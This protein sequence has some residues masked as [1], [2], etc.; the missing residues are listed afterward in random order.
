MMHASEHCAPDADPADATRGNARDYHADVA[1]FD[2]IPDDLK[3]LPQWVCWRKEPKVNGGFTKIP[4]NAYTGGNAQ[5]N[6]PAT[7][8]SYDTAVAAFTRGRGDGIGFVV[9]ANDPYC[10]IDLDHCRDPLTGHLNALAAEILARCD[11]Y[12]EVTPSGDGIRVWMKAQLSGSG[13]NDNNGFEVYDRARFF[14]MTGEH[15]GGTPPTIEPRQDIVAA[16]Y[17]K[18]FPNKTRDSTANGNGTAHTEFNEAEID[19]ALR[20]IPAVDRD[21]WWR[22]GMAI[23]FFDSSDKGYKKWVAWS[24]TCLEKFN[25]DDCQRVW[26][27]FGKSTPDKPITPKTIFDLAIARGWTQNIPPGHT[28]AAESEQ[29]ESTS[30]HVQWPVLDDAALFGLPGD[31]VRTID[32]HTESDQVAVLLNVLVGVGNVIGS[33]PH[34]MVGKDCHP[35]TENVLQVGETAKGRKGTGWSMPRYLLSLADADWA[36]DC[37]KSGLSS[38]EGLIYHVRDALYKKQPIKEKGRVVGYEDVMIEEAVEDKRLLIIEPE[39][40][41][42]L[43]VMNR[44]GNTLSAVIR[45]G[46]DRGNLSTLTRNSPLKATGAHISIIGHITK[47]ELLARLDDTSKGNG[48]ANRFLFALVRRSKEL[49]EGGMVP[50]IQLHALAARLKRVLTFTRTVTTIRRDDEAKALWASVYHDLSEPKPG[51]IGAVVARAEAHVLRLSL[52]YA[53]LDESDV[54][55]VEHLRAALAVWDYCE[56]S[57]VLIFGDKLGDPTA[58]RMLEAIRQAGTA[59]MTENDLYELFGRNKSANERTRALQFLLSLGLIQADKEETG[60]RPRTT[61]RAT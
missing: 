57:A 47:Q 44:E 23:H 22:V 13:G 41:S 19:D 45:D 30:P 16:L 20:Y 27:S 29:D 5:N 24:A 17:R 49:P 28:A 36:Q 59:G 4:L 39:F 26:R 61:Y 35:C 48:F 54:I 55:R 15:I 32:P 34:A 2:N 10:G 51:L 40:A 12:T 56:R 8:C 53:L 42:T 38:A 21:I 1:A 50:E 18:H 31:I 25:L 3:D 37:I 14:T 11:S 58:D 46:W 52:L 7:W 33:G 6:N 43:T 60:G 9:S